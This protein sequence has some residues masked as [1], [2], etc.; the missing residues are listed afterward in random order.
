ML[1]G[2]KPD[3]NILAILP[4]YILKSGEAFTGLEVME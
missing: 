3:V 2:V 1:P 4:S